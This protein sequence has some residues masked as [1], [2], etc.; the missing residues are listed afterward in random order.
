MSCPA[1]L[2]LASYTY[3]SLRFSMGLPDEKHPADREEIRG[4]FCLGGQAGYHRSRAILNFSQFSILPVFRKYEI[5]AIFRIEIRAYNGLI[6][7][8]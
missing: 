1:L 3:K 8:M 2:P 4:F 5:L 7:K 6:Q